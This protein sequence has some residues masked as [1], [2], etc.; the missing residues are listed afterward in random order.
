MEEESDNE[1]EYLFSFA[2]INKYYLFPFLAP[3]FCCLGNYFIHSVKNEYDNDTIDMNLFFLI[4]IDLSYL[5]GGLFYFISFIRTKTYETRNNAIQYKERSSSIVKYIYNDGSKKSKI[6]ITLILILISCLITIS[7]LCNLYS[8]GHTVFEK[9]LYFLFFIALLSKYILK[10]NIYKHQILSMTIAVTGMIILF[11]P[12]SLIIEKEDIFINIL[13]ILS[14]FFYSL[15]VVMIKYLTHYY[16]F[17]PLLCLLFIGIISIIISFLGFIVFSLIKYQDLSF[18]ID[19]F[20]FSQ[21]NIDIIFYIYIF[22]GLIFS[23]GL[24]LFTIYVIYYFSP[25]LLTVT[26]SISPMLSWVFSCIENGLGEYKYI[27]LIFNTTGYLIQLIAGLI[28]NEIII[29]NFCG[30]NDYTKK[31]LLKKGNQEI[32]SL[33]VT[34]RSTKNPENEYRKVEEINENSKENDSSYSS[35][36]EDDESNKSD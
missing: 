19:N 10:N 8:S 5:L 6:K 24:Q 27:N 15:F 22:A 20:D 23:T 28:Y 29:C 1:K 14:G 31:N 17:S 32:I 21:C 7:S 35:D 3:I 34:E 26:D 9:R 13:N 30:F 18:I 36:I 11:I 2:K 12:V 25:I 33:R 4:Y 16:Y